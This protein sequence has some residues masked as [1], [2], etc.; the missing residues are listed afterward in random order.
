MADL[1]GSR[2][3]DE[4]LVVLRAHPSVRSACRGSGA[5][6]EVEIVPET[7]SELAPA[8]A[9]QVVLSWQS[10]FDDCYTAGPPGDDEGRF[11]GWIDRFSG[12]PLPREHM[13]EWVESTVARV[14]DLS[15]SRVLEI[16]AGTGLLLVPLVERLALAEYLATDLSPISVDWLNQ[17]RH[18]LHTSHPATTVD[19][20]Q[21]SAVDVP[22][23]VN[24]QSYDTLIL[25]SVAQYFPSTTY[26]ERVLRNSVSHLSQGGHV[27]L[28]DL[29]HEGLRP[30]LTLATA[31]RRGEDGSA[32]ETRRR[33]LYENDGELSFLPEYIQSLS[34]RVPG[35]TAVDLLPRAGRLENEM[36]LFRF[37][38]VL[39]I[40]C[41]AGAASGRW[42]DADDLTSDDL[43]TLLRS[44]SQAFGIR[45]LRNAR[46][47]RAEHDLVDHGLASRRQSRP[48]FE[49][50]GLRVL[51]DDHGWRVD[52]R[53]SVPSGRGDLDAWYTPDD[54][55]HFH[56]VT[57]E[58]VARP[59]FRQP[60]L[61]PL[62][63]RPWVDVL[64][65]HLA[66]QLPGSRQPRTWS[67]VLS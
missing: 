61:P 66:R 36:T 31:L 44:E 52:L 17:A 40:G 39:H 27:Y 28:G 9:Q 11:V 15:P 29:R 2:V 38:A 57:A 24:G 20:L 37:D 19:V 48:V 63:Q 22:K 60:V 3:S 18:E 30:S 51:G 54:G 35:V 32:T 53:L 6:D 8:P 13:L 16:G 64:A 5:E 65:A 33:R 58:S 23:K 50:D 10:V 47:L 45:N 14:S 7:D 1:P 67:F 42:R 41:A 12:Q 49:P 4:V 56:A 55:G 43:E 34:E 59:Q 46:L 21:A 26:F 62:M 25:N